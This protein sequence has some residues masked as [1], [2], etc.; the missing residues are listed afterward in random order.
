M[1]CTPASLGGKGLGSLALLR[2]LSPP[3]VLA[4]LGIELRALPLE[5]GS[6]TFT[7]SLCFREGLVL[8]SRWTHEL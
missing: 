8:L 3:F 1:S 5:R 2:V 6:Q 7:F 4:V